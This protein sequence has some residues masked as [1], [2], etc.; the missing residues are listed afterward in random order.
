MPERD[1][2]CDEE[3]RSNS[4]ATFEAICDHVEGLIRNDAHSLIGGRA[5]MTA[6]LIVAQLAHVHHLTPPNE[7]ASVGG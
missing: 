4:S 5:D 2:T 1:W 3:G 6:R 7:K